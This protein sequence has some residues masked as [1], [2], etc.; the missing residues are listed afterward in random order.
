MPLPLIL[1]PPADADYFDA[2]AIDYYAFRFVISFFF[3]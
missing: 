3:I 2:E 1:M